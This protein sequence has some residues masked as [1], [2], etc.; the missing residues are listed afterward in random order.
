[1]PPDGGAAGGS[2]R[3]CFSAIGQA[4]R[5]RAVFLV[6]RRL[7]LAFDVRLFGTCGR[8]RHRAA[9]SGAIVGN[10]AGVH[11]GVGTRPGAFNRSVS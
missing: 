3:A 10:L 9:E 6:A 4:M 7:G 11:F 2:K 8:R 1:M 5:D